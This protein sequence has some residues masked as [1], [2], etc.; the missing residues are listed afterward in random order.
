MPQ[1]PI[2][3]DAYD[4]H[5]WR[6]CRN[7]ESSVWKRDRLWYLQFPVVH[8][9]RL[10][11]KGAYNW[12]FYYLELFFCYDWSQLLLTTNSSELGSSGNTGEIKTARKALATL[13][14][15]ADGPAQVSSLT[16]TSPN[17]WIVYG[18]HLCLFYIFFWMNETELC[19]KFL[20]ELLFSHEISWK[21]FEIGLKHCCF[22][23][24]KCCLCSII[25][26]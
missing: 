25:A 10:S 13:P 19:H 20:P 23:S 4:F 26:F 2:Q 22:L 8:K 14:H 9:T 18:I 1:W 3:G 17:V 16:D 6:K 5:M 21:V 11:F 12:I 7:W 15:K 24:D